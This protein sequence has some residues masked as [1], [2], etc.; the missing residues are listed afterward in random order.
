MRFHT[1]KYVLLPEQCRQCGIEWHL[2]TY[3]VSYGFGSTQ[4]VQGRQYKLHFVVC[5]Q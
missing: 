4:A 1:S 2:H 5:T 3:A